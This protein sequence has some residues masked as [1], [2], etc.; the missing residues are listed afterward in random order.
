MV[1]TQRR[2][3]NHLI[4]NNMDTIFVDGLYI[5]KPEKAPDFVKGKV[6]INVEKLGKFIK[7][8]KEHISNG[9]LNIDMLESK[10]GGLYFKLNT[11]KAEDQVKSF[12]DNT[13]L[14]E[15]PF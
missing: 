6:S 11:W 5:K 8:N 10:K 9:Y 1:Y 3:A 13:P 7:E 12:D 2:K 14:D 15:I 4:K